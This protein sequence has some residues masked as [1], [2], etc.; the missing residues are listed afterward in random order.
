M[1]LTLPN[2][3]CL[4]SDV[5]DALGT[6][7]AQLRLDDYNQA[8]GL[9]I[10]VTA[11]AAQGATAVNVTA[12]QSPL[13]AGS[14]LE[15]QGSNLPAVAEVVTSAVA[16]VGATSLTVAPLQAAVNQLATA[17][18]NGVNFA[19]AQRLVKACQYG[20]SQVK[21][22]CS[23]RYDDTDLYNNATERGSVNRWATA[24][25]SK[26]LCSRRGQS[27]PGSVAQDAK[28][29]LDELKMVRMGQLSIED[30]GT[31]SAGTPFI[32][33]VTVDISYTYAKMR[34]EQN[35]SE[36][37]PTQYGQYADWNSIFSLQWEY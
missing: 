15:F 21:L 24:L 14:V 32:T 26:W 35:L 3:Y 17:I 1:A 25:A 27:P 5:F 8:T 11:A 6:D 4:P 31:R 28:D 16:T 23:M 7:G 22:Y 29:A 37:T 34:V 19:L 30:I 36:M 9:T 2:L 18:D 20:T 13:L 10:Q 12:L 33:N